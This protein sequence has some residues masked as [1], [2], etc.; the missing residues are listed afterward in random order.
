M[1]EARKL[2]D[3]PL[4]AEQLREYWDLAGKMIAVET[5]GKHWAKIYAERRAIRE[6]AKGI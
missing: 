5:A 2:I 3:P 4:T 1:S 6:V